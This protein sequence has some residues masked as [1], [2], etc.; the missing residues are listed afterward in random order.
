MKLILM[1]APG[2]GKGTHGAAIRERYHLPVISTGDL[3][4]KAMQ[5]ETKAGEQAKAFV[6]AG[7]LVPDEMVIAMLEERLQATDCQKGYILD[8]FPRTIA[9]AQALEEMGIVIDRV[10]DLE[11]EDE[12]IVQRLAG[13]LVC[14]ECGA[15]YHI[16]YSPPTGANTCDHCNHPLSRREDDEPATILERLRIYHEQT[17]PLRD[18]YASRGKLYP[19]KGQDTVEATSKLVLAAVG[20]EV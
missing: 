20:S 7:K 8:G 15:T 3:I 5:A 13:R 11:V 1:G 2:A 17:E 18:Y 14:R 6:S 16:Q 10:I 12:V 4:R 19:V 9:Q